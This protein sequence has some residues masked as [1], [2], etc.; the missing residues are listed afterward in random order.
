MKKDVV[1]LQKL[2]K[3]KY[4]KPI[5][6]RISR[7]MYGRKFNAREIG[8]Y[9]SPG[10]G[11]MLYVWASKLPRNSTIV[12]IG[13]LYGLSTC[14]LTAGAQK[15]DSKVYAIDPFASNLE[16]QIKES[17]EEQNP[18]INRKQSKQEVK[19]TLRKR[20]LTSFEL[21]K[22]FSLDVARNG[23]QRPIDFIFIDGNHQ[24]VQEDYESWRQFLS[25]G[26][27][28]AFH[29]S[30]PSFKIKEVSDFVKSIVEKEKIAYLEQVASI[31]SFVLRK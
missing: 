23:W 12:E 9:L 20:G 16:R 8:G 3:N 24:Q 29:D 15:S 13:T 18:Y 28:V 26:S 31:T 11:A 30:N 19:R 17:D 21:I 6:H 1:K 7:L 25:N 2:W 10:E 4:S 27:R 22:G 5:R 14:Y